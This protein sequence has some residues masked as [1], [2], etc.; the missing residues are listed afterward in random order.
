M[1]A[2]I[3]HT[4]LAILPALFGFPI[5]IQFVHAQGPNIIEPDSA[6]NRVVPGNFDEIHG[7]D[8]TLRA[9]G[10]TTPPFT[11]D[12]EAGAVLTGSPS[13]GNA[14]EISVPEYT[15]NNAGTLD[16][17]ESGI[18]SFASSS[19]INN[20][21]GGIIRGE[22]SGI[23]YSQIS[24]AKTIQTIDE[25]LISGNV[26]NY[27]NISGNAYGIHGGTGLKIENFETGSIIGD[28][29]IG[30]DTGTDLNLTNAGVITGVR[31]LVRTTLGSI[32]IYGENGIGVFA[33][34]HATITN[35]G[36]ITGE[37]GSGIRSYDDLNLT[38]SGT[39]TGKSYVELDMEGTL[40]SKI[41]S[42]TSQ[43]YG[44][45]S[46]VYTGDNAVI[47]NQVD[48][49]IQ[50]HYDGITAGTSLELTNDGSIIGSHE[51]EGHAGVNAGDGA[52]II[53]SGQITG[54]QYGIIIGR[55][56]Y[57]G[58][59]V[60]ENGDSETLP[61]SS[62]VN[63]GTITSNNG[64]GVLF[65]SSATQT[66]DNYGTINGG[67]A[68]ET[69][70]NY[71]TTNG[72]AAAIVL[73]GGGDQVNL[74]SGS[75]VNGDIYAG[76]PE[77]ILRFFSGATT[78]SQPQN[79]VH[80]NV[81]GFGA[82][83]KSESGFAFI[84]GP[85]ESFE[86]FTNAINVSGGGLVINGDIFA[87]NEVPARL[88]NGDIYESAKT[89]VSLSNGGTLD[90]T[91]VWNIDMALG[92]G[93]I[94]AGA[95]DIL[96]NGGG[97]S[98]E[99]ALRSAKNGV[100][101]SANNAVGTLTLN[102][103]VA[104]SLEIIPIPL[105]NEAFAAAKSSVPPPAPATHVRVDI[106]PQTPIRNGINSDQ[107][108]QEGAGNSFDLTGVGIR[109]APTN[110]NLTLTEGRYTIID[111]DSPLLGVRQLGPVAV[112][113][114]PSAAE[115][116]RFKA[117]QGGRNNQNTV[118]AGY[119]VTVETAD[120]IS[121]VVTGATTARAAAEVIQNDPNDSDLIIDIQHDF[122][123]LPGLSS[124]QSQIGAALDRLVGNDNPLIQ[125]FIAAL[126]YSD[127]A[128]VQATLAG[129]DPSSTLGL[130][131]SVVNSNYR[132]H[133]QTQE[134]LAAIR[135]SGRQ[136]SEPGA[137][138]TDAKGGLV[139]GEPTSR[140]LSRGNAWGSLSYDGQDFEG[141]SSVRDFDGDSGSFTAGVDWLIAPQFVLGIVLDGSKSD[142]DGDGFSSD[143][144]SFRGAVYG[145]WGASLGFYSD[146]LLGFGDH[147]L[148]SERGPAGI[149]LGS[150][151]SDTDATSVQALWTVGYTLGNDQVR[152]G[153]FAGLEYQQVDVDGF[154]QNGPIPVQVE[155]YD[156][157]SL[158]ALIGYRVN[159]SYGP[160]RPYASIAYAHEFED[161]DTRATAFLAGESFSVSSAELS[162][163]VLL[164]V[165]TG[166]AVNDSLT[167]D[168][169]YR[170]EIAT[171]DG[172]SSHGGSL[173]LNYAF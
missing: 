72:E 67:K 171:D 112:D 65:A 102:G 33:D 134:H 74:R 36:S 172:I 62:V 137:S 117:T 105:P 40:V 93:G 159:A 140:T 104:Q 4:P 83:H 53:N 144:E 12:I 25:S 124:V 5:A 75:I 61:E 19:I 14:V 63:R 49:I 169:G 3:R 30:I 120:P 128:T 22:F 109:I 79:M 149:L 113:F 118:L 13:L 16:A 17:S 44:S 78:A 73:Q 69:L 52:K 45:A 127:L 11:V 135:G 88:E 90:G 58:K 95:N 77:E 54:D 23:G 91:G 141:P 132:L 160:F 32:P 153:P 29:G 133:R 97:N 20:L 85:G 81:Y 99:P 28:F 161:G 76:S 100:T 96:L 56:S 162:S 9:S 115:T 138:T 34:D 106:I 154:T 89:F 87:L 48:G 131:T 47:L 170:G 2:K 107:I 129:L 42:S 71:G 126:D 15:I 163:A 41:A 143:V 165:G 156:I 64:V 145:T 55:V 116:G 150:S 59:V 152:H 110:V 155:D 166:Y 168:I 86:V 167:L 130:V 8:W 114:S 164:T 103:R 18:L 148:D 119:F 94:S 31:G 27:G 121:P 84:G 46:A 123:G 39:I 139:P 70:K 38:N 1:K 173:G 43:Y 82:I 108:I 125:D 26:F 136:V 146:F 51:S 24:M 92:D 157:D 37:S 6:G 35:S 7:S 60:K 122:E 57:D 66:L 151:N 10:G 142:L 111:S 80:G 98:V 50:G 101:P 21:S 158:R 147:N 68:L